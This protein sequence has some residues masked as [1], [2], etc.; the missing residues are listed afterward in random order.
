MDKRWD[1]VKNNETLARNSRL[2]PAL[3][4]YFDGEYYKFD[5]GL[6]EELGW[7]DP[8]QFLHFMNRVV[9]PLLPLNSAESEVPTLEDV[10]EFL[11][12]SK[13][14]NE[15]GTKFFHKDWKAKNFDGSSTE[16]KHPVLGPTYTDS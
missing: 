12:L 10:N 11:D 2:M 1:F 8:N 13:E 9:N 7:A 5:A 4:V 6:N 15:R 16:G 3:F 14:P